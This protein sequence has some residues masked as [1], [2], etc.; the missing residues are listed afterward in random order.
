MPGRS[1][2]SRADR[3]APRCAAIASSAHHGGCRTR[4]PHR[5]VG[6]A[7]HMI[8]VEEVDEIRPIWVDEEPNR[9]GR[10]LSWHELSPTRLPVGARPKRPITA[11][12]EDGRFMAPE[13]WTIPG[14]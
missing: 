1:S 10:A 11:D 4:R 9:L 14:P 2:N 8:G 5:R 3:G 13:A 6:R 12:D 7:L